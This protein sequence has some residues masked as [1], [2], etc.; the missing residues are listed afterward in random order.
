MWCPVV[1]VIHHLDGKQPNVMH[2]LQR[3]PKDAVA[4]VTWIT[5]LMAVTMM[6][7]T[8][9]IN[10]NHVMCSLAT[11]T[12]CDHKPQPHHVI[13]IHNHVM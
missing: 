9:I 8:P 10:H 5:L 2:C 13:I 1:I 3:N 11:I 7:D 6:L 12:S 4:F